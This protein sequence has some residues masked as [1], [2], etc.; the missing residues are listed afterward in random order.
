MQEARQGHRRP[1]ADRRAVRREVHRAGRR[2]TSRRSAASAPARRRAR[3]SSGSTTTAV[4]DEVKTQVLMASLEQLAEEQTIA[5]L[6]PPD[7]DPTRSRSPKEGPFVYEFDVEVRPEFDLPDYKGL[8]LS[9]PIH[10]FT[11]AEVEAEKKRLLEPYGQLV[12]KE[13]PVVGA[14][15]LHHRRRDHHVRAARRSTSSRRC[16]SRSSR[17]WPCPTA[18]PRTSARR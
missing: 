12:P 15:R 14:R 8:K 16:G 1:R 4:A 7:L 11:D 5:P 17:S 3:S 18:S 6:S 10:T 2:A 13:P 9:R